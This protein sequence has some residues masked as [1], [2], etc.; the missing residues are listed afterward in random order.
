MNCPVNVRHQSNIYGV[1]LMAKFTAEERI[2]IIL[3]YL[4]GNESIAE[5][6]RDV[7][8]NTN[9]VSGWKET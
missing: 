1:L 6:A 8:G 9:I 3:R 4:N 7:Q 2:Q 5:I